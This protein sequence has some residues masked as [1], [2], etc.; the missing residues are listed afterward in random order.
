MAG[1]RRI[2][3]IA[4]KRIRINRTGTGSQGISPG[5]PVW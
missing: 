2:R 1:T 5:H 4:L 3:A